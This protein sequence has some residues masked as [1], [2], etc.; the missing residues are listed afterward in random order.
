MKTK[1][2]L[3]IKINLNHYNSF[4]DDLVGSALSDQ[5]SY[6]CV[7]NVHMLIE[8]HRTSS[9]AKVVNS[10]DMVTPDGKPLTWAPAV[11][12]WH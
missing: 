4:V 3:S 12:V 6:A 5:S 2:L 11:P 9:F 8:A 7:A 1:Q 10:A